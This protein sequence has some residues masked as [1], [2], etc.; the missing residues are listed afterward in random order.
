MK[1]SDTYRIALSVLCVLS[2]CR[3]SEVAGQQFGTN[4][5]DKPRSR[6]TYRIDIETLSSE[7]DIL[8]GD[9]VLVEVNISSS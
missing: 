5:T 2:L 4:K 9:D 6:D 7:P 1:R 8:S 3:P